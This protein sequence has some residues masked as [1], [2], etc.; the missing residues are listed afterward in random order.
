MLAIMF[1]TL[2]ASA[3]MTEAT[4]VSIKELQSMT[5][6]VWEQTYEACGRTIRVNTAI[7]VPQTEKIPLL[8]VKPMEPLSE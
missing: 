4:P 6:P 1:S 2:C 7:V 5:G 8:A 3:A